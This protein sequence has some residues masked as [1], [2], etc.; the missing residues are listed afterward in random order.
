MCGFLGYVSL[1]ARLAALPLDLLRHRGPDGEG[2][3]LCVGESGRARALLGATRLS[4]ID[5]SSAGHM[6]MTYPGLPITIVYNGEVYNF[7]ELRRE[8][9][10]RGERFL[11]GTDTEVVLRGYHIWGDAVVERL[12]GMFAFAL[13]DGRG[14]GRLLLARDRFGQKPLYY[15]Q[16]G[17][18]LC[19]GSE[20]KAILSDGP[21]RQLDRSALRYYLDRGYPP[22]DRCLLQGYRKVLP[23]HVVTWERDRLRDRAYWSPPELEDLSRPISLRAAADELRERLSEAVRIRLVADVPVGALLSGGVDSAAIIAWVA[24]FA[25]GALRTYTACF[26]AAGLDESERARQTALWIGSE[27]R[28]VMIN[29]RAGSILPFIASHADE[30]I[31]D[32]SAIATYLICRRARREVTVLLTGDGSDE[33]LLG[34]PRYRL[35]ALAQQVARMPTSLRRAASALL[36]DGPLS[37]GLAAVPQDPLL[38][39]RYWLDHQGQ[40]FGAYQTARRRLSSDEAVRTVLLDDVRTWLVEDVLTKLDKM[41]MAASVEARS[42]FLDHL[43]AGWAM[44]LP[45]WARMSWLSGKAILREAMKDRL[46]PHVR[47]RRKKAFL[48]PIDEWLRSEWRPLARDVLLDRTT[49]ERGWT[50]ESE[51]HR[52]LDEHVTGRANHGRRIYQLLVL[53]LW[54]RTILDRGRAEPAPE[55]VD[56][57]ARDLDPARPVRKVAVIAPAGIGDTIRLTPAIRQLGQADPNVSVTLY[58]DAARESDAPM[59]GFAPVDR[60]LPVSFHGPVLRKV[61]TLLS[62]LRRS[63]PDQLLSTWVSVLAGPVGLLSGVRDRRTWAPRWSVPLRLSVLPWRTRRPYQPPSADAGTYDVRAFLRLAGHDGSADLAPSFAAPIWQE[64]ACQQASNALLK[65]P[66]PILAISPAA[67]PNIRQRE[68]PMD[69]MAAVL[70][71]LLVRGIART[72]LLLGDSAARQR[73]EPLKEAAGPCCLNLAGELSLSATAAVL[74]QCDAALVVDGALLHVALSSDL[75]VVALYGPTMV[76]AR[77][78]RGTPERYH[79]LSAF[80]QCR[81]ICLPHR[82]I[83]ARRECRHQAQCLGTI[84]PERLVQAVEAALSQSA[85]QSRRPHYERPAA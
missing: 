14:D 27:H 15:W 59:A 30:P 48:L 77:D 43:L 69:R 8:L 2:Q 21:P 25:P 64:A 73:L 80:E 44:R 9:E 11:S 20:L 58:V 81:C 65:L 83:R 50:D 17:N 29:P 51:V 10:G 53:E 61:A 47:G 78:P 74:R 46:P 85:A 36:P 79:V 31:A 37:K 12:R 84:P 34:Y 66:R 13:W 26:G 49:R 67:A 23:G 76:F 75:P 32:P 60:H 63:R 72:A 55:G 5:L 16:A 39:D 45:I 42:P 62:D 33:L 35:H 24:R 3:Q 22:P 28:S 7:R 54:A 56:D 6:P 68:Y 52:L 1:E 18:T 57:C 71:Q 82:G 19:F 41:S 70:Q 38:R 4:I 40:R